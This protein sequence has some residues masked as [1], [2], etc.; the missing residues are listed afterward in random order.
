[1][2]DLKT[3]SDQF[4]VLGAWVGRFVKRHVELILAFAFAKNLL[5]LPC[6]LLWDLVVVVGAIALEVAWLGFLFGSVVGVV[7]VLI[8]APGLFIAPLGLLG[9]VVSP[10]PEIDA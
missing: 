9:L 8:F 7:L 6:R 1:M 2:S 10:W 3:S 4:Y 5:L